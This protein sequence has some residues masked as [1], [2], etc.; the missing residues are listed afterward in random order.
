LSSFTVVRLDAFLNLACG[1]PHDVIG[2]A[3]H[4][5]RG[6]SAFRFGWH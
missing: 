6:A 2:N 5:M 4:V 1:D 3:I